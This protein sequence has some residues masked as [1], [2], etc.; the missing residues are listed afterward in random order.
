[1]TGNARAM[2]SD[3]RPELVRRIL[4]EKPAVEAK[5][6]GR[7]RL[8]VGSRGL[9]AWDG[10]VPVEGRDY[11]LRVTYPGAYPGLP[12]VLTTTLGLPPNCPHIWN[13]FGSESTI[14]WLAPDAS[15]PRRRWDPQ[16][17]TAATAM[18]AAQRWFQALL[19]WITLGVWPVPDAY[20]MDT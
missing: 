17:H 16:R 13:R 5:F 10:S 11:P 9:P 8:M 4:W 18:H 12:P 15:D 3:L 19:V 20:D 6:P 7:F 1:M 14:C 2:L